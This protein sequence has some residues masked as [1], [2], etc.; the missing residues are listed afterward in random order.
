MVDIANMKA[1]VDGK[2]QAAR[3]EIAEI[4]RNKQ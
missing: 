3:I 1:T 2:A 4:L